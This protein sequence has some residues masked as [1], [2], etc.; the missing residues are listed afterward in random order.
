M[1]V[2]ILGSTSGLHEKGWKWGWKFLCNEKGFTAISCKPF[3][4]H[5]ALA[6]IRTP[7][8]Q[9]RSLLLYP[10][11]PPAHEGAYMR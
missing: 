3:F 9:V 5:G 2:Q 8:L 6:G 1:P 10:A 11:E 7:D 4:K